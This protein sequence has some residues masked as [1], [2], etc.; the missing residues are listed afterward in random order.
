MPD[1]GDGNVKN[2][3]ADVLE[4]LM[5][6]LYDGEV[7]PREMPSQQQFGF[8]LS[9]IKSAYKEHHADIS[10]YN[11][12]N[13]TQQQRFA[14]HLPTDYATPNATF[15]GAEEL[16]KGF[17]ESFKD[18]VDG[19]DEKPPVNQVMQQF[20]NHYGDFRKA[21]D[22]AQ[23]EHN[24]RG[25]LTA[26]VNRIVHDLQS[27]FET[28]LKESSSFEAFTPEFIEAPTWTTSL[29]QD[30]L[31]RIKE[32]QTE[33]GFRG[34]TLKENLEE[35]FE[36]HQL[37]KSPEGEMNEATIKQ[38]EFKR[39]QLAEKI[40][41]LSHIGH[42]GKAMTSTFELAKSSGDDNISLYVQSNFR[43]MSAYHESYI[44][45]RLGLETHDLSHDMKTHRLSTVLEDGLSEKEMGFIKG[46][47]EAGKDQARESNGVDKHERD[48]LIEDAT[49]II[50]TL[51]KDGVDITDAN[52]FDSKVA[53]LGLNN[54]E[55]AASKG[56]E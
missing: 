14:E 34:M 23:Q 9:D 19:W 6:K 38:E 49:K 17:M 54:A 41:E 21:Y 3:F 25:D 43:D 47:V 2:I 36:K 44:D 27:G 22:I 5:R 24:S 55:P 26:S 35:V 52:E 31:Q 12:A 13:P 50:S 53:S 29:T 48:A 7:Q 8:V 39:E 1:K 51:K 56:R 10:K 30:V 32:Q 45:D 42:D 46:W 37:Y 4:N 40:V 11:E 33:P 16:R 18:A 28:V 20:D 15:K